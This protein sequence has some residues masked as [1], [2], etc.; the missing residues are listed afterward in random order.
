MVE[1][2]RNTVL[3]TG[4]PGFIGKQLLLRLA[5]RS[6]GDRFVL[7]IE[8]RMRERAEE[9]LAALDSPG[10]GRLVERCELQP[11]DISRTLLGLE[12]DRYEEL[13]NQVRVVWHLAAIYDLA[14]APERAH[15]VNVIG[16]TNILDFCEACP[17]L[18]GLAYVS[19]CYVS[20]RRKGIILEDELDCGQS[21]KNHYESTKFW[22]ELEVQR[23]KKLPWIIFRPSIV[24]GD[25][26][27][28][29]TEKY[30]GPYFVMQLLRHVPRWLPMV[31]V[32]QGEAVVNLTPVDFTVEAM[33]E[34]ASNPEAKH[35]VF[36]LA[37]PHALKSREL[38]QLMLQMMGKRPAVGSVPPALI[39]GLMSI[40][41][42]RRLLGVPRE[43]FE[44][45]N[46]DAIYDSTNTQK[47]LAGTGISCPPIR[48]YLPTL[49][50]YMVEHPKPR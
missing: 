31:N 20:G 40:G 48:E 46:H 25:S 2:T 13:A 30:D 6:P 8:E 19:T 49:Y 42:L 45:F 24:V 47:L 7:L 41:P 3:M 1:Q 9:A 22:A 23:R 35:R 38:M 39:N 28:G 32:G 4:F 34:I 36:Q 50:Q 10:E 15:R 16:T 12:P 29:E 37:D 27:T 26:K 11:G 14:V 5:R 33:A 17:G 44:Y 18:D 21:F 43:L